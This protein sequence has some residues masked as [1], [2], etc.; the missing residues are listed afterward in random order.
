M[1][2]LPILVLIAATM[3]SSCKILGLEKEEEDNS[4]MLMALALAA[5]GS[6]SDTC[7]TEASSFGSGNTTY[8]ALCNPTSGGAGRFFTVQGINV[9]ASNAF[10]AIFL[11]FSSQP[12][13]AAATVTAAG[14][15]G[16][17]VIQTGKSN[18]ATDSWTYLKNAGQAAFGNTGEAWGVN[19]PNIYAVGNTNQEMC[20][21]V[22]P[23]TNTP[24]FVVWYTGTNGANC[25]SRTG[26]TQANAVLNFVGWTDAGTN[27]ITLGQAY[28]RFSNTLSFNASRIIVSSRSNF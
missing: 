16:Q 25:A 23:G 19:T 14:S 1:K 22:V 10:L 17:Y 15:A 3:T 13:G 20:F 8:L 5:A 27:P 11:G 4:T 6:T 12:A 28:Y 21:E 2:I 9:P 18:G 7:T 24:R 26:L